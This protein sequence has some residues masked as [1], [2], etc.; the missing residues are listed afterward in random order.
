MLAAYHGDEAA[1]SEHVETDEEKAIAR[2]DGLLPTVGRHA[3][4]LLH[5]GLGRDDAA[6]TAPSSASA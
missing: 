4:T 6:L 5:N 3:R 1:L 2:G